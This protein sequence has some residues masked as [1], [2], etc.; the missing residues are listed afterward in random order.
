MAHDDAVQSV[1]L[2]MQDHFHDLDDDPDAV[3]GEYARVERDGDRLIV[4][5]ETED[6]GIEI[7]VKALDA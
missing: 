4:R 6:W 7:T 3:F 5:H 1:L 2:D